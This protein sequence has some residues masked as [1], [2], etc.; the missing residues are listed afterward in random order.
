MADSNTVPSR[1]SI[2]SIDADERDAF[3]SAEPNKPLND[4]LPE[5]SAATGSAAAAQAPLTSF[6]ADEEQQTEPH[7]QTQT[8]TRGQQQAAVAFILATLRLHTGYAIMMNIFGYRYCAPDRPMPVFSNIIDTCA[9]LDVAMIVPGAFSVVSMLVTLIVLAIVMPAGKSISMHILAAFLASMV[10]ALL[11]CTA[12]SRTPVPARVGQAI[13][14]VWISMG[15][16][17]KFGGVYW[18]IAAITARIFPR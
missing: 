10:Y 7:A 5:Y 11:V 16:E 15:L 17:L 3:L 12:F 9:G 1:S 13:F 6:D 8:L 18:V 4:D 2:D 14:V